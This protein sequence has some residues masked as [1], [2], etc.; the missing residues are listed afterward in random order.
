MDDLMSLLGVKLHSAASADAGLP[1]PLPLD[2]AW[3][4]PPAFMAPAESDGE[5]DGDD[6][7]FQKAIQVSPS[8]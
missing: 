3:S 8:L 7:D 6:E 1:R 4:Q 5:D 2:K